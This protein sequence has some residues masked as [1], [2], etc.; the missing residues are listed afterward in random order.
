MIV[1]DDGS[2]D[3]TA[4]IVREIAQTDPRVRLET[5]HRCPPAGA[6]RTSPAISSPRSR[7]IRSS[8]SWTPTC[9]SR[10]PTRSR[11]SSQFVEQSGATLVSGIPREETRGLMEKLIIPLIHFVFLGFLPLRPHAAGPTRASPPPAAR[12]RRAPRRL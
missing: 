9:A 12:S 3:R 4:E 8:F 5:A 11:A 7:A 6:A 1:L 2:T 10:A